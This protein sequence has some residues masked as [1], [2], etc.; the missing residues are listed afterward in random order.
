MRAKWRKKRMRSMQKFPFT[1][2]LTIF[3]T[4][5]KKKKDEGQVQVESLLRISTPITLL[6]DF[7]AVFIWSLVGL[8]LQSSW[9]E[10]C[11]ELPSSLD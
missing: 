11:Q 5:A 3:E 2:S 9:R 6:D 10:G 1:L 4:E 7:T 8:D